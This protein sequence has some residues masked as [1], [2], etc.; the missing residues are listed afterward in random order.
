MRRIA[1]AVAVSGVACAGAST[2]WAQPAQTT[3]TVVTTERTPTYVKTPVRAPRNAFELGVNTGYTQPFGEL[4]QGRSIGDVVD[5]GLGVGVDLGYRISPRVGIGIATTYHES[6]A[7]SSIRANTNI[8]GGTTGIYGTYHFAP[9]ERIDPYFTLGT[10]YRMLWRVTDGPGGNATTH[11]FEIGK[12]QIGADVRASKDVAIGPFIG[13]DLNVLPWENPEGSVGNVAV[14]NRRVNTFLYAGLAGR[15]DFG[16]RREIEKEITYALTPVRTYFVSDVNETERQARRAAEERAKGTQLFIDPAIL[17]ACSINQPKT[18]FDFDSAD[19][20]TD[21]MSTLDKVALCVT[22]GPLKGR[23]LEIVGHA[24]PRGTYAYNEK[25]GSSRAQSVSSYLTGKGVSSPSIT[26][27][28]VGESE[29]TG[30]E[31]QGW[32]Y[33]RRVDIRLVP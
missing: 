11:G 19:V 33:D 23:R 6:L 24:D 14:A 28:S 26:T 25:L 32:A 9:Y 17:G 4:S 22:D 13:A 10:G 30:T 7:D 31:P 2:A 27:E 15:F 18:F 5:G 29:A 21:D 8:R 16:G 1:I 20:K 3:T 12:A